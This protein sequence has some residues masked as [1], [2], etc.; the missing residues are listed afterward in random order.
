M[1]AR[2]Y[3]S[4]VYELTRRGRRFR[5]RDGQRLR[6]AHRPAD[7]QPGHRAVR[8]LH[9]AHGWTPEVMLVRDIPWR[10]SIR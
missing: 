3:A 10:V 6:Q 5:Q 2:Q 9:A 4:I 8:A 1:I 7:R